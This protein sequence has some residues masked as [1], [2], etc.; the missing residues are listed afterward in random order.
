[1]TVYVDRLPAK[2]WGKWNSGAHM[3]GSDIDELHAMASQI[4][5]KRA[6]FQD[7][8]HQH[9]DLTAS[10]RALAVEAGAV[11]IGIGE[12]PDDA[13]M[14]CRDGSLETWGERKARMDARRAERD[15]SNA[16]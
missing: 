6:W 2:G 10:K 15:N 11:E 12:T 5:L 16:T 9:Y 8:S 3:L 7:K 14:R 1:M 4:G 13:L